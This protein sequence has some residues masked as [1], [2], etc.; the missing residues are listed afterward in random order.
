MGANNNCLKTLLEHAFKKLLDRI[1][2][3][4]CG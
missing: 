2:N 3:V 4:H 1:M